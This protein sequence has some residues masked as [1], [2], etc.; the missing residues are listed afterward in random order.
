MSDVQFAD[1]TSRGCAKVNIST[2]LKV[3]F[4]EANREYLMQN[5]GRNDPPSQL[6]SVRSHLVA[7][8]IHHIDAIGSAGRA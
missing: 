6:S 2:A 3:A 4:T 7:V 5:P 1:L 8:A